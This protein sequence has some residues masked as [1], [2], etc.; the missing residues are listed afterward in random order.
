[1]NLVDLA[2]VIVIGLGVLI[3][4]KNGLIGPLL[5]EGTFLL[6]YWIVATPPSLVGI[7]P[8]RVPPGDPRPFPAGNQLLRKP[9][10]PATRAQPAGTARGPVRRAPADHRPARHLAASALA[11]SRDRKRI[12]KPDNTI[13]AA[14]TT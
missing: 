6:S 14:T 7:I 11:F 8:A 3:G 2:I 12:Q 4:W 1:M 10:A 9:P 13:T 5:A